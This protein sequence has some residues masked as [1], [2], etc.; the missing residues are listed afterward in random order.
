MYPYYLAAV[1]AIFVAILSREAAIYRLHV[2]Y[3]EVLDKMG[4]LEFFERDYL[5]QRYPYRGWGRMLRIHGPFDRAILLLFAVSHVLTVFL[6]L[7]IVA[8]SVW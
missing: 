1:A 2:K 8:K 7:V 4:S 3:Q 5:F 6:V